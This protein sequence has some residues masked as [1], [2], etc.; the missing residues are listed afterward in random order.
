[1]AFTLNMGRR[2]GTLFEAFFETFSEAFARCRRAAEGA[3]ACTRLVFACTAPTSFIPPLMNRCPRV[4][5]FIFALSTSIPLR[6][7]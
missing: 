3:V 2:V 7:C 6:C 1:M 5:H 4:G